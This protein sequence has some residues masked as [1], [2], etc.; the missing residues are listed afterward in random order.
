MGSVMHTRTRTK[1]FQPSKPGHELGYQ[2]ESERWL[3]P[4]FRAL[5]A[6]K[7][8]GAADSGV[9]RG[10][11]ANPAIIASIATSSHEC[12]SLEPQP[13]DIILVDLS[14]LDLE[15]LSWALQVRAVL[16]HPELVFMTYDATDPVTSGLQELGL[17]YVVPGDEAARWVS[18]NV[19]ALA[20]MARAK[21][22]IDFSRSRASK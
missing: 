17:E 14:N 2:G 15:P 16:G 22:C 1:I 6:S 4:P 12:T 18:E 19:T 7:R 5:V 21:R 8:Q 9:M 20:T 3:Q 13:Y 10:L 11:S